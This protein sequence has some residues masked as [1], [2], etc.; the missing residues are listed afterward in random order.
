[1]SYLRPEK[2]PHIVLFLVKRHPLW[3]HF[4][5]RLVQARGERVPSRSARTKRGHTNS[6]VAWRTS[7]YH[8]TGERTFLSHL[9][10]CI[11]NT[12]DA[13]CPEKYFFTAVSFLYHLLA[14]AGNPTLY[15][16]PIN[17]I[18]SPLL[19][20]KCFENMTQVITW[21]SLLE[22]NLHILYF[23]AILMFT[24]TLLTETECSCQLFHVILVPFCGD[25]WL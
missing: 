6:T 7:N 17:N 5:A 18:L 19:V 21:Y 24:N 10:F 20:V 2:P 8:K 3:R 13:W 16:W 23:F 11:L 12:A 14:C 4:V 15:F 22:D 25:M 1:M 9:F